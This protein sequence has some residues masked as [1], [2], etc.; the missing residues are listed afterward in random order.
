RILPFQKR[1]NLPYVLASANLHVLSMGKNMSGLSH[2]S[3]IYGILSAGAPY[4]F[5][6]PTESHLGDLLRDCPYGFHVD[7]GDLSG[8][9]EVI[10]KAKKLDPQTLDVY[11]RQNTSFLKKNF[12]IRRSLEILQDEIFGIHGEPQKRTA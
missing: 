8:M 4:V 2:V 11:R 6:G 10:A 12:S 1:E 9:E 7:H 3:K 5:L